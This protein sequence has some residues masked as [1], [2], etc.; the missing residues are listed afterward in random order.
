MFLLLVLFAVLLF[1]LLSVA[2]WGWLL[3]LDALRRG[4]LVAVPLVCPFVLL[5]GALHSAWPGVR[6]GGVELLFWV[7]V[8]LV[9]VVV[10]VSFFLG[11]LDLFVFAA[12]GFGGSD[13]LF[14]VL[15]VGCLVWFLLVLVLVVGLLCELG[16]VAAGLWLVFVS[17]VLG[18]G[19]TWVLLRALLIGFLAALVPGALLD[20]A[21]LF[22]LLLRFVLLLSVLLFVV[23]I[24][25]VLRDIWMALLFGVVLARGVLLLVGVG[26]VRLVIGLPGLLE[27]AVPLVVVVIVGLLA[28]V[29]SLFAGGFFVRGLMAGAVRGYGCAMFSLSLRRVGM[30]FTNVV[31]VLYCLV[32][33][34][35][36]C[37][38]LIVFGGSGCCPLPLLGVVGGVVRVVFCFLVV[39]C[40]VVRYLA[41]RVRALFLVLH[42]CA[43]C[44]LLRVCGRVVF[45][46]HL[47][48][49]RA[50][51]LA[52]F[53][54]LVSYP[55]PVVALVGRLWGRLSGGSRGRVAVGRALWRVWSLFVFDDLLSDVVGRLGVDLRAAV[56]LLHRRLRAV[57]VSVGAAVL[58]A[59]RV[60]GLLAVLQ[61]G[62]VRVV[63]GPAG[64]F[65]LVAVFFVAGLLGSGSVGFV[66]VAALVEVGGVLVVVVAAGL[67]LR[68]A[69]GFGVAEFGCFAGGDVVVGVG[70]G[71]VWGLRGGLGDVGA[72]LGCF[73]G[74]FGRRV[75]GVLLLPR[76][77]GAV[78]GCRGWPG[79]AVV[80]GRPVLLFFRVSVA[81][82]F[83][84]GAVGRLGWAPLASVLGR[85]WAAVRAVVV[86]CAVGCP[87]L[88]CGLWPGSG[89]P[90]GCPFL[91]VAP[92][93]GRGCSVARGRW[94]GGCGRVLRSGPRCLGRLC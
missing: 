28:L 47:F 66:A 71:Q 16:L 59:V 68:L 45:V 32:F 19:F 39:C 42:S 6:L 41:R 78:V 15:V 55:V 61:V 74:L 83:V 24:V 43:L 82:M 85:L 54:A 10:L 53:V 11:A 69:V 8:G 90:L 21:G 91:S 12:W 92:G 62:V 40:E 14:G 73:V 93:F 81:A 76:L 86:S 7:S 31:G 22:V 29:V 36:F 67:R 25:W 26:L 46:L 17:V 33:G 27:L 88:F 20:G 79:Y 72:G 48:F 30:V 51:F 37:L 18:A 65:C 3:S 35:A 52:G 56:L 23:F 87:A 80:P 84:R 75:A 57:L 1:V 64:L 70:P 89:F 34:M 58:G 77:H 94:R 2:V 13:W 38:F 63:V 50:V 44:R 9:L 5:V 49:V 4:A 60:G